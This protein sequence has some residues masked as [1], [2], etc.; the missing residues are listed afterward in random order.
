VV[1]PANIS[2]PSSATAPSTPSAP[3]A[4]AHRGAHS[5]GESFLRIMTHA[6]DG[7]DHLQAG[8]DQVEAQAAAGQGSVA[9]AL[10]AATEASL[11]TQLTTTIA[12]K[13]VTAF[14]SIMDMTL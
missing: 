10:I 6:I 2:L 7:I 12:E 5:E 3:S 9:N 1:I 13:A 4:P 14:T 11:A 8:A